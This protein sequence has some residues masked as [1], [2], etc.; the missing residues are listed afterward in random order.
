MPGGVFGMG[1]RAARKEVKPRCPARIRIVARRILNGGDWAP[2]HVTIFAVP[3]RNARI[4]HCHVQQRK[5]M[6]ILC[7]RQG[8]RGRNLH[9]NPIPV[10]RCV[11]APEQSQLRLVAA[12]SRSA[13][14]AHDPDLVVIG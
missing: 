13:E 12:S 4:R 1:R 9:R 2:E 6:R 11:A 7:Q 8:S 5:Q 10:K 14:N 3:T